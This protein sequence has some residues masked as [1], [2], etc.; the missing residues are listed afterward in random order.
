MITALICTGAA[1]V[2][3]SAALGFFFWHDVRVFRLKVDLLAI[4]VEFKLKAESLNAF[5]EEDVKLCY[6]VIHCLIE[7]AGNLSLSVINLAAS[8]G[9]QERTLSS[10]RPEVQGIID[11]ALQKVTRRVADYIVKDTFD[12]RVFLY[13]SKREAK[14]KIKSDVK[15]R[16]AKSVEPLARYTVHSTH[17]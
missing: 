10:S 8:L 5:Q 14:K 3:F 4:L 16:I 12:G 2:A 7:T 1:S 11:E 15:N 9:A 17:C 13:K 6:K